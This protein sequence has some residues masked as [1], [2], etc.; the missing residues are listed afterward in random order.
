MGISP[1]VGMM[2]IK[3]IWQNDADSP[4]LVFLAGPSLNLGLVPLVYIC[5]KDVGLRRPFN[6]HQEGREWLNDN[7]FVAAVFGVN[8]FIF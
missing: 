1:K 2:P 3:R 7:P 5:L 8:P 4:H 6:I